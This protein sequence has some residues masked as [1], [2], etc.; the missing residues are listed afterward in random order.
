M[1]KRLS[2]I[3]L[4]AFHCLPAHSLSL[5]TG[6][7][8]DQFE[9]SDGS[10]SFQSHADGFSLEVSDSARGNSD[11]SY[12]ASAEKLTASSNSEL[13]SFDD[14]GLG[15][16]FYYD[17]SEDWW[18]GMDFQWASQSL[19]YENTSYLIE[20]ESESKSIFLSSGTD[21][22]YDHWKLDLS[23]SLGYGQN[24]RQSQYLETESNNQSFDPKFKSFDEDDDDQD[25][26]LRQQSNSES[27]DLGLSGA[28]NY[29]VFMDDTEDSLILVPSIQLS[30]LH[31]LNGEAITTGIYSS[32]RSDTSSTY[33]SNPET[34]STNA[35]LRL[36]L[37]AQKWS[38]S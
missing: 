33:S 20:E 25:I 26:A 10:E 18:L 35:A 34:R 36:S 19:S 23:A 17:L 32:G 9:L 5:N 31:S 28:I 37:L 30:Y 22:F 13:N 11:L 2:T 38:L 1:L 16:G 14:F 7:L 6:Y 29:I 21:W 15:L 27:F 8:A 4:I 12:S 3:G 24:E